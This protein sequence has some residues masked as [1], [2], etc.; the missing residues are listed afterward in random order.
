MIFVPGAGI[1]FIA[2]YKYCQ[3]VNFA[4][5]NERSPNYTVLKIFKLY[6]QDYRG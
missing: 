3:Y 6:K 2:G 1:G 5:F 4:E